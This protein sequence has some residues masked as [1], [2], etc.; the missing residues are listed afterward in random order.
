VGLGKAGTL[1]SRIK[2]SFTPMGVDE[3]VELHVRG[4]RDADRCGLIG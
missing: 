3:Y 2:G 1:H 4:K